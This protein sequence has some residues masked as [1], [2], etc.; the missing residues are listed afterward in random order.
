MAPLRFVGCRVDVSP[1]SLSLIIAFQT[2][3]V[4]IKIRYYLFMWNTTKSVPKAEQNS[5]YTA[6]STCVCFFQQERVWIALPSVIM[7]AVGVLA[8]LALLY[9]PETLGKPMCQT[10]KEAEAMDRLIIFI[11]PL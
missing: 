3:N 4:L 11:L 1:I 10:V 2:M 9:L 8:G 7:G 5:C 6:S